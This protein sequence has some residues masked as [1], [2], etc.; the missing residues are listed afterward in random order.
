MQVNVYNCTGVKGCCLKSQPEIPPMN[1]C[2]S[3]QFTFDNLPAKYWKK[4]QYASRFV[5]LVRS[6]TPKITLYTTK[7][8]CM[9]MENSPN[10]D[11]EVHY[12]DGEMTAFAN[13]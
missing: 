5:N 7:A 10:A 2:D 11:F 12:Y 4:Y 13:Q 6:K 3:Q 1:G 9:L 8:K